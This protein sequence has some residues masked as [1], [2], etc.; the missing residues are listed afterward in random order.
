MATNYPR[1]PTDPTVGPIG[2]RVIDYS[3][4]DQDVSDRP[5][6]GVYVGTSGH[7]AVE[8]VDGSIGT[9]SNLPV[10]EHAMQIRTIYQTGSTAAGLVVY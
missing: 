6:R 5:V 4:G 10:G 1:V 2:V 8:M 9:F 3:G 7:L